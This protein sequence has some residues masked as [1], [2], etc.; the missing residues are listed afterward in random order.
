MSIYYIYLYINYIYIL[1]IFIYF[2]SHIKINN[3]KYTFV[4]ILYEFSICM[5][6]RGRV[7]GE[8]NVFIVPHGASL[9]VQLIKNLPE[10]QETLA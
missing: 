2:T 7:Y 3:V 8:K 5:A 4:E 1:Y 9:V 6:M 10:M